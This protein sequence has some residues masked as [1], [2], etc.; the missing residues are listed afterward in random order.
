MVSACLEAFRATRDPAWSLEA[1]RAFEWFLGRNDLGLA[2]YDSSTGGCLRRFAPGPPQSKSGSGILPRFPPLSCRIES[3]GTRYHRPRTRSR[4]S[5]TP[6]RLCR[7]DVSFQP[8]SARV[9][10]RPFIPGNLKTVTGILSRAIAITEEEAAAQL[11]ALRNDFSSR[12]F[13]IESI[14]LAHYEKVRPHISSK[15]P[16]TRIRQL[17]IGALFSGE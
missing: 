12:H 11:E 9:I 6:I 16:L 15:H 1:K 10:I 13:D 3:R 2:L 14:L 4:S 8:E 17:L 5:M 7:H